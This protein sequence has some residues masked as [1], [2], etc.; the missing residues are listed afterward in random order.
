MAYTVWKNSQ[1]L[2][3]TCI[4]LFTHLTF[5][6]VWYVPGTVVGAQDP[7]WTKYNNIWPD[8]TCVLVVET[9]DKADE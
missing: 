8:G 7:Q 4:Q 3:Q 1:V 5:C 6:F 2:V 9:V